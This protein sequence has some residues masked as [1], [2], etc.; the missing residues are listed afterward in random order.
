MPPPIIR[1]PIEDLDLPPKNNGVTRP[2]L[3]FFTPEIAQYIHSN[4]TTLTHDIDMQSMGLLLEVWNT[5]NVQAEV[6]C[7]DS[8][9]FDDFVDAMRY[10]ETSPTCELLEEVHCAVL[11]LI[12]DDKGKLQTGKG[13]LDLVV[14]SEESSD[15]PP[16][17]SELSTPQPDAPAHSTR[18]RLSHVDPSFDNPRSPNTPSLQHRA[19]DML[20]ERSWRDRLAARDFADGG[21]QVIY[22]GLLHQLSHSAAFKTRCE[23]VLA[24]LAPMDMQP[25]PSTAREQFAKLDVN[26]RMSALQMVTILSIGT[27]RVKEFMEQ[28]SED[29]TE[30]RK[31]KI[32]H[33][34]S[35]KVCT[36]ELQIKDRERK[37]LW[38][39]NMP[40][41]PKQASA[42]LEQTPVDGE[43]DDTL[44]TNGAGSSDDEAPSAGRSLRRGNDRKR[45]RDEDAA[46]REK[47]RAEKAAAAKEN[48][49]QSKEFKKILHDI[50][51]LK[52][53]VAEHEEKISDC[54]ADLREANVQRTKVLGKDRYCNRYYWFERNGQ[55][56]G[57]LPS[58][59]TAAYG[60]ANGRIWV[61]GPD[62]MEAEGFIDR[63]PEEQRE[64]QARFHMTVPERRRREEGET[65][66]KNAQEWGF[67]D[68]PARLENL[69]G[70]LDDRGEREKKLR[71]ELC[72]WREPIVQYM[73]AYKEF[74]EQE[75]AKKLEVDEEQAT[76]IST[77]H[78][79]HEDQ[80]AARERCLR[81]TNTMAKDTLGHIHSRPPPPKAKGGSK[82]KLELRQPKGVA[83]PLNRNGKPVTRQGLI[84]K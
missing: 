60:Y 17:E 21:W 41:S 68:D 6:Y 74:Q 53:K 50:E 65:T 69:I 48:S 77:R 32:E 9:T 51:D 13:M 84:S 2:E 30:V 82:L 35:K 62:K 83:V 47:E 14:E 70:W 11:T 27:Q 20:G 81:W 18:S 40:E 79:T 29:M 15:E 7:L 10:H 71:R 19:A 1:Y 25:T 5:L 3:K 59:S 42:E 12:V 37:I 8:F 56:F 54:D 26:L 57:G 64:Y 75:A 33:Q 4:R 23:K 72:D 46:R 63:M 45:K 38:P 22:I 44:E 39:A 73:E 49:K 55:P 31:R 52:S 58:S 78:K 67:Y 28:C 16:D 43:G 24:E 66:L 34:R 36:E 76:R 61:Q 80:S